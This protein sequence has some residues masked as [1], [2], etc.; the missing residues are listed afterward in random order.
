MAEYT[1]R[2]KAEA[3][4]VE[5][6]HVSD[7]FAALME[8][9]SERSHGMSREQAELTG[10]LEETTRAILRAWL[11]RGL[12]EQPALS[13]RELA[14]RISE[15]GQQVRQSVIAHAEAIVLQ[16]VMT[17]SQAARWWQGPRRGARKLLAGRY[18]LTHEPT[19]SPP[20]ETAERFD[21]AIR[22]EARGL[23]NPSVCA[24]Q[25]FSIIALRKDGVATELAVG[26]L[27]LAH[28]LDEVTRHVLR[29]WLLRGVGS[30]PPTLDFAEGPP[31]EGMVYRLSAQG[32][33][34]RAS[35]VAHAEAIALEGILSADQAEFSKR[36]LWAR[37]GVPA[38]VDP[39][40]AARLKLSREQREQL[41]LLLEDR[42]VVLH[43]TH[44][45]PAAIK[46]ETSA[47]LMRGELTKEEAQG[48][49]IRAES[50]QKKQANVVDRSILEILTPAQMRSL[51]RLLGRPAPQPAA[52]GSK[53][54]GGR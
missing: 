34:L 43:E 21:G 18:A 46:M 24:S 28:Q 11:L 22:G 48:L 33:R 44:R 19:D 10:R 51:A 29:A 13:P 40:L 16:G 31:T 17:P 45:S 53:R 36:L 20:I 42:E 6:G 49:R 39:E 7:L 1:A 27:A 26:E 4:R 2:L 12:D 52:Q 50:E 37:L 23:L 9:N 14:D 3:A 47:A 8:S 30:E 38:L 41:K 35:I 54:A 5:R 15:P 32:D 25:L